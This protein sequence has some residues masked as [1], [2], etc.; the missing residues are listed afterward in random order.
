MSFGLN[1]T[2]K[3]GPILRPRSG[4]GWMGVFG[5]GRSWAY[6]CSIVII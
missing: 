4:V 1:P 6:L 3:I 2:F 5:G